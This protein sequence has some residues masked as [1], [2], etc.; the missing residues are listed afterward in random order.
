MA[1]KIINNFLI[2]TIMSVMQKAI[3]FL[4]LPFITYYIS[5]SELGLV[6]QVI[7]IGT[8]FILF[9]MFALDEAASRFY[10]EYR[11]DKIMLPKALGSVLY[12]SISIVIIGGLIVYIFHNLFYGTFIKNISIQ[13]ILL[14]ILLIISTPMYSIYIKLLRIQEKANKFVVIS[15]LNIFLQIIFIYIFVIYMK[16]SALGYMLSLSLSMFTLALFSFYEIVKYNKLSFDKNIA[17]D[18]LI[19]SAKIVPHTFSSWGLSSFTIL[20]IGW[21]LGNSKVG[22]YS[23]MYY[24]SIIVSVLADALLYTYQPWLY[25]ILES[26]NNVKNIFIE[27]ITIFNIVFILIAFFLSLFSDEIIKILFSEKYYNDINIAPILIYSSVVLFTGS[28][29]TYVLY[30]YK[31]ATKEIAKATIIGV[32]VNIILSLLLIPI[33]DLYGAAIALFS[34]QIIIAVIKQHYS[35]QTLQ[36]TKNLYKVYLLIIFNILITIYALGMQWSWNIK[37]IIFLIESIL[38]FI[39]YK[40]IFSMFFIKII[41][42]YSI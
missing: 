21:Y 32:F 9:F 18:A 29:H 11:N 27:T 12:M 23:I 41:K 5:P 1:K 33:F 19:Y 34:S 6:N 40:K 17:K 36:I 13:F 24:I 7:A 42:G 26:K 28:L 16:L 35:L 10:F 38:L 15:F 22:L 37:I 20:V 2:Y 8:V 31:H 30:Y 3:S 14:S 39:V 4:I 25:K